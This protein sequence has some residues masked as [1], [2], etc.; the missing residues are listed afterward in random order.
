MKDKDYSNL[1]FILNSP[2]RCQH[3]NSD[4]TRCRKKSKFSRAYHGDQELYG[5]DNCTGWLVVELCE[6]HA[7]KTFNVPNDLGSIKTVIYRKA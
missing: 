4:G 5:Y 6:Q 3:L 7:K 2:N 1:Y